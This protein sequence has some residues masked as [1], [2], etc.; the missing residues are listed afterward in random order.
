MDLGTCKETE[1]KRTAKAFAVYS[2]H[3][4]ERLYMAPQQNSSRADLMI[5]L[6]IKIAWAIFG[7]VGH[8]A[9]EDEGQCRG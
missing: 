6:K 3:L 5:C 4:P 1:G 8:E 2:L 9:D 7:A